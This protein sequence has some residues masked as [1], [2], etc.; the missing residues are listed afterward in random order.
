MNLP[1]WVDR[2]DTAVDRRVES[3][4]GNPVIDRVAYSASE[5]GDFGVVWMLVAAVPALITG[6]P[7][8]GRA[9]IR[10]GIA[11]AL[12]SLIVNQG[13]KRHFRRER[14]QRSEDTNHALRKPLT[15]SFPS[16]HATSAATAAVL[17][18]DTLPVPRSVVWAAAAAV[19]ASR[20][21]V[22]AHH[23]SDVVGGTVVGLVCG[24]V[25]RRLLPV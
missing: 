9:L 5:A 23:A 19:A 21:H 1:V 15:S 12:E 24:R 6:S 18:S 10:M 2:F 16:G 20:V 4:R 17:L 13:I 8:H 25:L 3:L 14:P 22:K 11:L 7:R